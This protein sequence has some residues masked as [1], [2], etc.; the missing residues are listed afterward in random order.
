M[1]FCASGAFR[2]RAAAYDGYDISGLGTVLW[3]A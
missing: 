1:T 3:N 2:A